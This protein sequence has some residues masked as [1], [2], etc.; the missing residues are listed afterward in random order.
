[1]AKH[2]DVISNETGANYKDT[3]FRKLFHDEKRAIELC[4]AVAGTNYPDDVPV[5]IY[6]LDSGSLLARY[7]DVAFSIDSEVIVMCE[8]QSTIS[9][10]M[11]LRFLAYISN[12]IYKN[13]AL[14]RKLY[15]R[16]LLKIPTPKF[17]VL[18]NGKEKLKETTL[19]LSSAYM[20]KEDEAKLELIVSVID[21][22]HESA[23]TIL[24]RSPSLKGYAYLIAE[25]E[26]R[27]VDG[28]PQDKAIKEGVELCI[29]QDVLA[30]FLKENYEEV[31]RMLNLQYD[32]ETESKV[33]RSESREEGRKE[34]REEEKLDFAR[35]LLAD[36]VETEKIIKW[37]GLDTE[38]LN[39]LRK[40]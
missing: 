37:T 40:V 34:G 39:E 7:N 13:F 23:G 15:S 11:A 27:M 30:R 18:Y 12:T 25:I 4:N 20:L 21:I 6:S 1:M 3:V 10:N 9:P 29:R 33:I 17:Y 19:R 26:K 28:V 35:K 14:G 36:G 24:S 5:E 22:N 31:C 8:H 32:A 2:Q 16:K 38:T